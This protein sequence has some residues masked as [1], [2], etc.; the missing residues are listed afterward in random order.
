MSLTMHKQNLRFLIVFL[1]S[2]IHSFAYAMPD[3]REKVAQLSADSVDLN[4]Q[5]HYGTYTGNVKLDQGTTHLR[6]I[7][8]IT[9]GDEKNKLKLAVAQGDEKNQAHYWVQTAIDKPLVHAYADIIRYYPNDH[10]IELIG[11][12]RVIQGEDSFSAPKIRYDT[13]KHHVSTQAEGK[14][15]TTII[16]HPGN[17]HE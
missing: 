15:R 1:V 10:L 16:I 7:K 4:Q 8:A 9:E 6:A 13:L 5:S 14:M 2:F 3:D 11:N 12:A 17:H